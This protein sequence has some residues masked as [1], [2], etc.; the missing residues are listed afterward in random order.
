LVERLKGEDPI[1]FWLAGLLAQQ[2][3]EGFA[4]GPLAWYELSNAVTDRLIDSH[5]S[6]APKSQRGILGERALSRVIECIH[7]N[8]ER[9]LSVDMLAD[10]AQQSRSHFPR[11]FRCTVGLSPYQYVVKV[12][13]ERAISLLRTGRLSIAV[14]AAETGCADQSHMCRWMRRAYGGSPIRLAARFT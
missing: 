10:A 3:A 7:A 9:E 6:R 14:I 4:D 13:L 8:A 1:L 12:R 5:L 11:L 2:A